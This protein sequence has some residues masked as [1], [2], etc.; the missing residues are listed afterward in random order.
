MTDDITGKTI[1]IYVNDIS[2]I[3]NV[4]LWNT[5]YIH[6]KKPDEMADFDGKNPV[7][8]DGTTPRFRII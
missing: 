4:T 8:V 6:V 7:V 5:R 1:Q 3:V 2:Y